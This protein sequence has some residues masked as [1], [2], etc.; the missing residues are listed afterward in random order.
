MT[1]V[2]RLFPLFLALS[3]ICSI[4]LAVPPVVPADVRELVP[5]RLLPLIHSAEVQHELR[6]SSQQMTELEECFARLDGPWFRSRIQPDDKRFSD[7]EKLEDELKNWAIKALSEKQFSRLKQLELQSLGTRMFFR[8]DIAG[9]LKLTASQRNKFTELARSTQKAQAQLQEATRKSQPAEE[10]E[11][12]CKQAMEAEQH[13]LETVLTS[14]QKQKLSPMVGASFDLSQLKRIYPLAPEFAE[15]TEWINSQPLSLQSL[16]GKV[17]VVHF[18]A[19]QC[20]NCHA[21]FDIYRRWHKKWQDKD[22]VVI[23]IQSPE[24]DQERK[25]DAVR[26]AAKDRNLEFPIIMDGEMKNWT[27][28]ANTMWPTV[29]VIDKHGYIRHWWQGELNWQG[30]TGDKTIEEVVEAALAEK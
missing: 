10:L 2:T 16:R 6:L 18:Y 25:Y 23:G 5:F 1:L 26:Q 21:N 19:F 13:A 30:A 15:G 3:G 9:A 29:Y 8:N 17:V 27:A 11:K 12:A 4:A 22:V 28:W 7:L 14:S 20:H 24:T